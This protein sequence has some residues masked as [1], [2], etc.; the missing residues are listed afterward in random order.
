MEV[1]KTM[2]T[3]RLLAGEMAVVFNDK[4]KTGERSLKVWGWGS[5]DYIKAKQVLEL[6]GCTVK[7]VVLTR[8]VKDFNGKRTYTQIRLHV[9]E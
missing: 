4:L 5:A 9:T 8:T 2:K 3:A 1:T 6:A 7:K